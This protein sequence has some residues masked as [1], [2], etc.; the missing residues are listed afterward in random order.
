MIERFFEWL[1][2]LAG[3]VALCIGVGFA[4]VFAAATFFIKWWLLPL[5]LI[6][7]GLALYLFA[8]ARTHTILIWSAATLK[9]F[10]CPQCDGCGVE[11]LDPDDHKWKII[12]LGLRIYGDNRPEFDT[13][14]PLGNIRTCKLCHGLLKVW[15]TGY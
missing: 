3:Y 7:Y 1:F 8:H 15:F 5:M 4:I 13:S 10:K 12:P 2:K 11:W 9:S 14:S 6:G